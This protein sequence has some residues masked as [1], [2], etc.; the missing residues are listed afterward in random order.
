MSTRHMV[1]RRI[2]LIGGVSVVLVGC[3]P[4]TA[5]GGGREDVSSST[6]P[7]WTDLG[8]FLTM[9]TIAAPLGGALAGALE[10]GGLATAL[11]TVGVLAS[12]ADRIYDYIEVAKKLRLDRFLLSASDPAPKPFIVPENGNINDFDSV[13]VFRNNVALQLGVVNEMGANF[14]EHD[15]YATIRRVDATAPRT[16]SE[17]FGSSELP[18]VIV[19]PAPDGNWNQQIDMG[20][21]PPGAY[22]S[23]SWRV[24]R[25][26]QPSDDYI[27][28][29]GF[30]GPPFLSIDDANY[31][32]DLAEA[33]EP[34]RNV[35]AR[36]QLPDASL[37]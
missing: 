19:S 21:L 2:V 31:S 15:I 12:E 10:L 20:A 35:E 14:G 6:L 3:D 23:Y 34:G 26:R 7:S 37:V 30:I 4:P 25:G 17:I 32:V 24:P 29:T 27:A 16:Y 8:L 5:G 33:V 18:H 22:V 28:S 1:T 13:P 11:R 9:A 36:F